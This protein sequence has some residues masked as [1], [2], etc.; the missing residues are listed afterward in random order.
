MKTLTK[1]AGIGLFITTLAG[2]A[3]TTSTA[4]YNEDASR[5]YNLAQAGGLY[6]ARDTILGDEEYSSAMS[7]VT[8]A[9]SDAALFNSSAGLGLSGGTSL[10]L[11]LAGAIFSAPGH[12]KRDSAFAFV[13][14]SEATSRNEANSLLFSSFKHAVENAV[15]GLELRID[16][17]ASIYSHSA[18]NDR[19]A[20]TISLVSEEL[21]C[22][23][24]EKIKTIE[25]AK[26]YACYVTLQVP[27]LSNRTSKAPDFLDT[28]DEVYTYP[29]TNHNDYMRYITIINE[30]STLDRISL[31]M[32][33]SKNMPEWFYIY[34]S[35][36]DGNPPL[37]LEKGEVELFITN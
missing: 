20:M 26:T 14:A 25:D 31:S 24:V 36:K 17:E 21:G 35:P 33:I 16:E 6:K 9:F 27:S 3:T 32:R 11:G 4:P 15:T 8:T 1:V 10:G 22:Y 18:P 23:G 37:I 30:K 28:N 34:L 5:A 13:P 19:T 2:C 12:M 29:A 7:N